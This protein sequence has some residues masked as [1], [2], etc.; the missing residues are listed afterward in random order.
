MVQQHPPTHVP[1]QLVHTG[2]LRPWPYWCTQALNPGDSTQPSGLVAMDG[3]LLLQEFIQP[4]FK[5]IQIGGHHD[6]LW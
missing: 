1:Q 6:I 4:P 3:L 2:L 5:A